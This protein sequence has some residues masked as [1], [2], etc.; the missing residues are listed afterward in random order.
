MFREL[1]CMD[2]PNTFILEQGKKASGLLQ[3]L[4]DGVRPKM[5]MNYY[6]THLQLVRRHVARVLVQERA[7]LNET[8]WSLC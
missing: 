4:R 8:G 6:S 2:H 5:E 3:Y 7:R 1:V